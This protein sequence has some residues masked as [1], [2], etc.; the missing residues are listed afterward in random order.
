[1]HS[2][3][4]YICIL[5]AI[6]WLCT[7]FSAHVSDNRIIMIKHVPWTFW[8]FIDLSSCVLLQVK[9]SLLW[10]NFKTIDSSFICSATQSLRYR[11]SC[12][13]RTLIQAHI[14]ETLEKVGPLL[15]LPKM[16]NF[17]TQPLDTLET[18][19]TFVMV[20]RLICMS[21]HAYNTLPAIKESHTGF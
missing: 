15:S 20:R 19:C 5:V 21:I 10:H 2:S 17:L 13:I 6:R 12:I 9:S 7:S 14:L 3:Y 18:L 4:S 11:R 16:P 1:M 8:S